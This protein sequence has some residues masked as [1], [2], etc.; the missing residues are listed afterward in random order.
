MRAKGWDYL[1][2]MI[3]DCQDV[4]DF[5]QS[6]SFKQFEDDKKLNKAVIYSLL[7][8]GELMKS[9]PEDDKLANSKIPWKTIIGFRDRAA[10]GYKELRLDIVWSIVTKHIPPLLIELQKKFAELAEQAKNPST[11]E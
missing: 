7:N 9:F 8:L 11:E 6:V 10:H 1:S 4:V 5:T 2:H 3:E